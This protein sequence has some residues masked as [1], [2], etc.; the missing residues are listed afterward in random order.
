MN[1]R[2]NILVMI[3]HDL[4]DHLN[5]YGH[6][7]VRSPSLNRM[8]EE[9]IRFTN[10]FTT[11]PECSPSRSGFYTGFQ[12]HQNGMMGLSS[13]GWRLNAD[14]P[15]LAKRLSNGGYETLLFGF[16]HEALHDPAEACEQLGYRQIRAQ[17]NHDV[18]HVCSELAKFIRDESQ[19]LNVDQDGRP[20]LACAGFHHVHR[21]WP[22]NRDFNVDELEVPQ[23]LDDTPITR[24]EIA[25]LH[26]SI[27]DMDSA[28]GDVLNALRET[29]QKENTVVLFT[30]DHGIAF[31]GAKATFYDPGIKLAG[32]LW[33]GGISCCREI[34]GLVSNLDFAPTFLAIAGIEPPTE[35]RGR[36]L[37]PLINGE[38][39]KEREAVYGSLFYDVAYDP[40]H[41]VRT[42]DY[43][44]IRSFAVF[45]RDKEDVEEG[46]MTTFAAGHLV[47]VDD[48]DVLTSPTWQ[49]MKREMPKPCREELYCLREDPLE[50]NNVVDNIEYASI[51]VKMRE[52]MNRMMRETNSPLLDGH[53]APTEE[54]KAVSKRYACD[55]ELFKET[56]EKRRLEC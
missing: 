11:S 17:G 29:G 16:Q 24:E 2:P 40:M 30:T 3:P 55:G 47:R 34:D 22:E 48:F 44:Y 37:A 10:L 4:G 41:Y 23:Y 46:V 9:G 14:T 56:C 13:F 53:V 18:T 1:E 31:P 43:K 42:K 15:H 7:S 19:S 52:L 20:W 28:I 49:E 35:M 12:P 36:S 39:Y 54:Q 27:Y 33:G 21:Q 25:Q 50:R 32:I 51:L 38:S 6:L 8:A 26:Q 45:E 5:C